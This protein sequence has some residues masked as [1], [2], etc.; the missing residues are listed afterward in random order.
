MLCQFV[1]GTSY[2]LDNPHGAFRPFGAWFPSHPFSS[3]N[4]A[5]EC[6]MS[7]ATSDAKQ[8]AKAM[9]RR[10][11]NATERHERQQRQAQRDI[12]A[13]HHALHDL[14][15][16][17]DLL[18]EIAGRVR[19]QKKR[20][21][22]LFALL[23]PTLFGCRSAHELTRTRGWDKHWPS[24]LLGA[25][26]K[27]SWLTRLRQLGP[28]I[29]SAMGRRSQSM[30]PATR[31][32]W[33]LTP[34]LDDSVL[35]TYGGP[36]ALVGRCWSGQHKRVVN[37]MEG[38]L[39]LIVIGDG[40]RVVPIDVVVRR[41]NPK[42]PGR[43]CR[44]KLPWST[45]RRDETLS[46]LARRGLPLPP[47]IVVADRGLSASKWRRHV[48]NAHQGTLLVQGQ[49]IYTL[50][51][52]EGRKVHGRDVM[53]D[54]TWPWHQSLHAPGCRYARLRATSPTYGAVTVILVDKPGAERF[55][56]VSLATQGQVTRVLRAW[57]RRNLI[58][59][60]CRI[61]KPLVATEACQGRSAD[62]YYGH[63][64]LRLMASFILYSTSRVI[65]KGRVT[66]DEMGFDLKHSWSSVICEPLE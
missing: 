37:G 8:H 6:T 12:A 11:L 20:L 56:L 14:A 19:S 52:D 28:D 62:A 13:L 39:L 34:G 2:F 15:V 5:Q 17:D 21:G 38:V 53:Q 29:V 66:M 42:G 65:F 41:P 23:C 1:T 10:R 44:E 45:V 54:D 47:P 59:H 36:L 4:D 48:S 63:L 30:S 50:Y 7:P 24:R 22:T 18:S 58:E 27:R 57:S 16:P 26:P 35:R 33:Q 61:L 40:H 25:L 55:S 43:R 46:A 31:S 3:T 9:T 60:V 51:L 49:A 32:R 64:V